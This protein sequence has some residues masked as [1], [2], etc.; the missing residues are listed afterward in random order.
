[1]KK[2]KNMKKPFQTSTP[3]IPIWAREV[4][5]SLIKKKKEKKKDYVCHSG[6]LPNGGATTSVS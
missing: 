5:D 4:A 1:M 6:S 2:E 3:R